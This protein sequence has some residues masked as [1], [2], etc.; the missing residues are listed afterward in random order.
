MDHAP[1]VTRKSVSFVRFR[2]PLHLIHFICDN[3][4]FTY[5]DTIFK[6]QDGLAMGT[7]SAVNLANHYLLMLIDP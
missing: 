6:Q 5:N 7:N 1:T 4:F 2:A 3:D